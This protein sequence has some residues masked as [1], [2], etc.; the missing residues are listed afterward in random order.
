MADESGVEVVLLRQ[1]DLEHDQLAR[2]QFVELVEDGRFE[3]LFGF[4]LFRAVDI[5]FRLDD[6]HEARGDDLPGCFELLGHDV[7]DTRSV[8]DRKST[9][10]NSSHGYISYA[11]FCLKKKNRGPVS[12]RVPSSTYS[13]L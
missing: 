13:A 8:G 4:G 9:R 7:L 10:L 3:Q 12:C 11:V 5:H 6:R 1:G 2:W